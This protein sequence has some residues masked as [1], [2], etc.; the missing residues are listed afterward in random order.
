MEETDVV[1]G[2]SKNACYY[3]DTTLVFIL[4]SLFILQSRLFV[5][6]DVT[7]NIH[8][9]RKRCYMTRHHFD[10]HSQSGHPTAQPCG[11]DTQIVD[12]FQ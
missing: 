9:H 3:K 7:L 10:M 2:Y 12:A 8:R 6:R 5:T 4:L 1:A 11:A